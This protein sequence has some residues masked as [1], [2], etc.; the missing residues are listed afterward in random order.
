VD[1]FESII[2]NKECPAS[3][4]EEALLALHRMG[5]HG[6][7][8]SASDCPRCKEQHVWMQEQWQKRRD[9]MNAF[10]PIWEHL[11]GRP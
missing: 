1:A 2:E 10:S 8:G 6:S 3:I 7:M 9:A 11:R 4:K 5:M